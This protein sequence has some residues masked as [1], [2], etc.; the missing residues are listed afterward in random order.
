ML[1]KFKQIQDNG[2]VIFQ[3]NDSSVCN[4]MDLDLQD[5][6]IIGNITKQ[7]GKYSLFFYNETTIHTDIE[8]VYDSILDVVGNT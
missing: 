4:I 8:D 2:I 6:D 3:S 1:N 5:N 7:G